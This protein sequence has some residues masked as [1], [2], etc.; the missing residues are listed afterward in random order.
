MP[1][2]FN[3]PPPQQPQSPTRRQRRKA[4]RADK[5]LWTKARKI[6]VNKRNGK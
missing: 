3:C 4:Q 2:L 6:A 5:R 1:I